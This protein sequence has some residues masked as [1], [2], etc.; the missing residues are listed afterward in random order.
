MA[1][2]K[3]N[4]IGIS[5]LAAAVPS[6]VLDNLA[7]N[8]WFTEKE[9][10]SV[11]KMTGIKE[12]RVAPAEMCASDLCFAAADKL[13]TEMQID[14]NTVDVLIF[15]SQTPDYRMPATGII[16]QGRLGLGKATAALDINLG[17]SGYIYGLSLAYSYC[18]QPGIKRVLLLNGETRTKVYSFKDKSTGLLFGDGGAATLIEKTEGNGDSY[19]SLH[20][21]GKRSH[22]IMIKS[23]GY[24]NMST[25]ESLQEKQYEDGS[26]RNDEQGIM[27]GAGVFDFTIQDIPKDIEHTL[28]YAQAAISDIDF[29]LLHQANKFIT[30]H[31]ARKMGISAE[32]VPYSL[33]K[34]GNTSSV[35]IPLTMVSELG[36]QLRNNKLKL[37][38]TGFGVGLSWGTCILNTDHIHVCNLSEI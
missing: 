10:K 17:C 1:R 6:R 30:D 15:I 24:R 16:L 37:L 31:I 8:E 35:S 5:G 20:A 2:L 13:L 14:R 7:P 36:E 33:Q 4:N 25:A 21:D 19:F 22:Y 28:E 26:R 34:F 27:D 11:V 18:L 32:K 12:R 9:A 29:F 3:F 23:G 38:M